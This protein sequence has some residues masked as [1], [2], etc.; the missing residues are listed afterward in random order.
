MEA[1][2]LES[3]KISFATGV[4]M[5]HTDQKRSGL[6]RQIEEAFSSVERPSDGKIAQMSREFEDH[7]ANLVQRY[8]KG[9]NWRDI[10][11]SDLIRAYPGD[12]SACLAFMRPQAYRYFLPAFMTIS[13]QDY[14][15]ADVLSTATVAALIPPSHDKQ[16]RSHFLERAKLFSSDQV[17]AI[18]SFLEYMAQ[19]HP[20]EADRAHVESA[21]SFWKRH[22]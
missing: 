7:E 2:G 11:L 4:F 17:R 14:E 21:I 12:H 9:L 15:R 8:F 1:H 13:V 16:L 3:T 5:R 19:N 18:M 22:V 6:V 10:R 20:D